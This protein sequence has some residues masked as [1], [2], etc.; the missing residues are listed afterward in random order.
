MSAGGGD[1][2]F[3]LETM[4]A[5]LAR[6]LKQDPATIDDD[7]NLIDLGLDSIRAMMLVQKWQERGVRIE[8]S[9]LAEHLTLAAWWE[10]IAPRLTGA[11]G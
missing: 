11:D 5:D 8:F 7:E 2:A 4:R 6:I 1:M 9:E 3:D 10:V